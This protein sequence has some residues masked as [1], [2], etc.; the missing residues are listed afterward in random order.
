[1]IRR[2]PSPAGGEHYARLEI[3][4][5]ATIK[6]LLLITSNPQLDDLFS[7]MAV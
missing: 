4:K 6:Q 5:A 7:K 1:L 2:R 3:N